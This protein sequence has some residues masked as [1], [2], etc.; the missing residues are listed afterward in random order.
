MKK[1]NIFIIILAIF[2]LTSC[3]AKKDLKSLYVNSF[4][5]AMKGIES[6]THPEQIKDLIQPLKEND[7]I[8]IKLNNSK[9]VQ[10]SLQ[11]DPFSYFDEAAFDTPEYNDYIYY[12]DG[13]AYI[14]LGDLH[15]DSNNNAMV[16]VD[17]YVT[18]IN[19]GIYP[20][21]YAT[22]KNSDNFN[23]TIS[24]ELNKGKG[25]YVIELVA[26]NGSTC[27]IDIDVSNSKNIKFSPRGWSELVGD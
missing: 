5:E 1:I 6:D 20:V 16:V 2:C 14:R 24:K 12:K 8:E 10:E 13:Y 23:Y 19:A 25:V 3:V 4:I 26:K 15:F 21:C 9:F 7:N 11:E 18:S 27:V 17:G 22:V